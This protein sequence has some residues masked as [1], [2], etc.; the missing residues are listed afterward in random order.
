MRTGNRGRPQVLINTDQLAYMLQLHFKVPH[1][2]RLFGVSVRTIRRRMGAAGLCVSD[3]YSI[4]SDAQL[5]EV[6]RNLCD[7]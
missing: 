5:D 6:V 4:L 3:L 1:I 7:T 2:A